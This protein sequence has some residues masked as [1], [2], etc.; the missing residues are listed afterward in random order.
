VLSRDWEINLALAALLPGF[1]LVGPPA[2]SAFHRTPKEA[3]S[4]LPRR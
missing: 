2:G 4:L 3:A 1:L